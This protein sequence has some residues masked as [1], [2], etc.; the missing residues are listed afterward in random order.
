MFLSTQE[1]LHTVKCNTYLWLVKM[2]NMK[3]MTFYQFYDM[4]FLY[5]HSFPHMKFIF[6]I[7]KYVVK[8]I[9]VN[10]HRIKTGSA[11]KLLI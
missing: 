3:F 2:E 7:M 10:R 4:R 9:S 11:S 5:F 1:V 8:Y 6:I